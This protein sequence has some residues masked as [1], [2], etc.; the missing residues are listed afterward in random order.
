M[1]TRK[2]RDAGMDDRMNGSPDAVYLPHPP[3][4]GQ[5]QQRNSHPLEPVTAKPRSDTPP[6][7]TSDGDGDQ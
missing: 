4:A 1:L 7:A 6:A 5:R 3:V 2:Q